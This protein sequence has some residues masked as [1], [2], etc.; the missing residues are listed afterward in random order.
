MPSSSESTNNF[1]GSPQSIYSRDIFN[2]PS[3]LPEN[4][5]PH[6]SLPGIQKSQTVDQDNQFT[7]T[8]Q[9]T[10]R[11]AKLVEIPHKEEIYLRNQTKLK[12]EDSSQKQEDQL[13]K[14][15]LNDMQKL[16]IDEGRSQSQ[17]L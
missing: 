1:Y 17:A 9:I 14:V 10:Q 2:N 11:A 12:M 6:D 7:A 13:I 4:H 15:L 5:F 16:K 8:S 3:L